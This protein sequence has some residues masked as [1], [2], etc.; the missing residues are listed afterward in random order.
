MVN[1]KIVAINYSFS[2]Y[3]DE[4]YFRCM[5]NH[6]NE[7]ISKDWIKQSYHSNTYPVKTVALEVGWILNTKYGQIFL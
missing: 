2:Q 3:V 1:E 4:E 6:R 7:K 5:F